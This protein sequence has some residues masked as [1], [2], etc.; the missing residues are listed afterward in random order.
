MKDFDEW[1]DE[2]ELYG[3]RRERFGWD[4]IDDTDIKTM[5]KWLQAAYEAGAKSKEEQ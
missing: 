4:V 3:T 1:L 2:A 5:T